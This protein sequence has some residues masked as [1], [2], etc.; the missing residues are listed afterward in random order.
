[1]KMTFRWFGQGDTVTLERIRQIPVID[2][3]VTALDTPPGEA[4]AEKD[5]EKLKQ[6]INNN[7][8][9]FE[10]VESVPVHEDIKLGLASRDKYIENYII[11]IKRLAKAGV[12]VICYNFMP[13]FDWM[14]SNLNKPNKDKS[15]SLAYD[16]EID[17][18]STRL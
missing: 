3:I 18:K 15:T 11:T 12:K 13:V 9:E 7:G 14:R 16:N 1:M 10:V 2:G 5:I 8:L 6:E 17:R 4:W